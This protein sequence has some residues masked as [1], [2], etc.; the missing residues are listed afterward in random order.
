MLLYRAKLLN[1]S[2]KSNL[3]RSFSLF[4]SKKNAFFKPIVHKTAKKWPLIWDFIHIFNIFVAEKQIPTIKSFAM[5]V[6]HSLSALLLLAMTGNA[7]WAQ[8]VDQSEALTRASRFLGLQNRAPS[9]GDAAQQLTLAYKSAAGDETYYYVFNHADGGFVIVGGDQAAAEI[10]GYSEEGSFQYDQLPPQMQWWLGQYDKEISHAIRGIKEGTMRFDQQALNNSHRAARPEIP[11]LISTKWNQAKPYNGLIPGPANQATGCVATATAQVMNFH[12]WPEQGTGTHSYTQNWGSYGTVTYQANFGATTYDW[13]NM[14]DT[15]TSTYSGTVSEKAVATL[16]YHAGVASDMTYGLSSTGGSGTTT[17]S[18]AIG[19]AEYFRYSKDMVYVMRDFYSDEDWEDLVY[20]ELA[21]NRPLIYGGDSSEGGHEFVCDGYLDGKFHINWGWGGA[22]N[23]YCL[24]TST[25]PAVVLNPDGTGIGGSTAGESYSNGQEM[26]IN[27]RPDYTG[28]SQYKKYAYCNDYVLTANTAT[29]GTLLY[30][31]GF[32]FNGGLTELTYNFAVKFVNTADETDVQYV[33]SSSEFTLTAGQGRKPMSFQ[34]P[35]TVTP[36]ATYKVYPMY[37]DENND[38][39]EVALK[40]SF[41]VPTLKVT[42]PSGVILSKPFEQTN[43]GYLSENSFNITFSLKNYAST[44]IKK[45]YIVY[46][47]NANTG[48]SDGYYIMFNETLN[49]GQEKDYTITYADLGFFE[50]FVAGTDYVY[51]IREYSTSNILS[52]Q[53]LMHF[54]NDLNIDYTLTSAEWG[55]LCL[56]YEAT[57]PAGLTAYSV[58]GV[59]GSTLTKTE[60]TKLEMNKPYL[61]TGTPGTY[62]FKGP[63]TPEKEALANGLLYGNTTTAQTYAPVNSYVLQNIPAQSGLAFYK[64]SAS[65]QKVGQYRAYLY[66]PALTDVFTFT[67]DDTTD[68][69][70]LEAEEEQTAPAYNLQGQR[71]NG[72]KGL[73]IMNGKINFIK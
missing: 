31:D 54:V 5:K 4:F 8:T 62:Q 29:I 60:A 30:I 35:A 51:D 43:E 56:P 27:L 18:M 45:N 10:L 7:A 57:V 22:Y 11:I 33:D 2:Q 32:I 25:N 9:Q 40:N 19:L 14:K 39:Q 46:F 69:N 73:V 34:V 55:T 1:I 65:N 49:A 3:P 44:A 41:V 37:Y 20:N 23:N 71:V 47:F 6:L 36:G 64:V 70:Q 21:N 59:S 52:G 17:L 38:L 26:I 16:M 61:I 15:Y 24:L 66:S 72:K 58:T 50:A 68:I 67:D 13:D 42:A 48:D 28:T 63:Q 53:T 12:K